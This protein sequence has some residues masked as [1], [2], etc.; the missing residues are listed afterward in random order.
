MSSATETELLLLHKVTVQQQQKTWFLLK[1]FLGWAK[2]RVTLIKS[3]SY[4]L[5]IVI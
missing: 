2:Q 4:I 3:C 5:A 1:L